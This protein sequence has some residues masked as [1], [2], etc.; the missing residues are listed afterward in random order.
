M[1]QQPAA[2]VS[3]HLVSSV[4]LVVVSVVAISVVLLPEHEPVAP[5]V[6]FVELAVTQLLASLSLVARFLSST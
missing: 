3:M 2:V 5:E 4:V 6:V 1:Q